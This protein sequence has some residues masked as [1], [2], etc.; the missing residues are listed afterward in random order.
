MDKE[1]VSVELNRILDDLEALRESATGIQRRIE[2]LKEVLEGH[3]SKPRRSRA[4]RPAADGRDCRAVSA[5]V[6][7]LSVGVNDGLATARS[8]RIIRPAGC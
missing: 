6:K 3:R 8:S 4:M 7:L 2:K 1:K 5:S